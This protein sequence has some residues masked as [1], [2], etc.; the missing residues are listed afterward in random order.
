MCFQA[1]P[2]KACRQMRSQIFC[3]MKQKNAVNTLCIHEAFCDIW[4][5]ICKHMTYRAVRRALCGVAFVILGY[6]QAVRQRTLTPSPVGSNP[7]TPTIKGRYS[8]EMLCL[9]FLRFFKSE[10]RY[11]AIHEIFSCKLSLKHDACKSSFP[12]TRLIMEGL[13]RTCFSIQK[14]CDH[15]LRAA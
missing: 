6:S 11:P 2:H 10:L 1:I 14:V 8:D 7:A 9:P 12:D 4:R 13:F 3:Q 15:S 5:K